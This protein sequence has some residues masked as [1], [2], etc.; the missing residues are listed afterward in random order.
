MHQLLWGNKHASITMGKQ[1]CINCYGETNMHQLLWGNKHASITMGKQTCINYYGETNMQITNMHQL[2]WGNKHASITMEKQTCINYYGE[3]N[4][5]QLVWGSKH[6][7]ITVGKLYITHHFTSLITVQDSV[8][9][10][11]LPFT[12]QHITSAGWQ[13]QALHVPIAAS[14]RTNPDPSRP[15][16]YAVPTCDHYV[17]LYIG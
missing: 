5:H 17:C 8:H 6:V 7:S 13:C 2:L 1:T 9:H 10:S 15:L 4:M 3:T 14:G 16:R 12:E 11:F